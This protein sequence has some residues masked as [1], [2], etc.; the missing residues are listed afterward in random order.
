M[1]MTRRELERCHGISPCQLVL[2][3]TTKVGGIK[4]ECGQIKSISDTK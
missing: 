1:R 4:M 3:I 2:C